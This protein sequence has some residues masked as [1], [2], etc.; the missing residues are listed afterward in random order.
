MNISTILEGCEMLDLQY[1]SDK[2]KIKYYVKKRKKS[3]I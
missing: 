1:I 2:M 3:E